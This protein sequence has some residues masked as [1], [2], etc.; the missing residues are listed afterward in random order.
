VVEQ[1]VE[2]IYEVEYVAIIYIYLYIT[3]TLI[4]ILSI[5]HASQKPDTGLVN[6]TILKAE[7]DVL[8]SRETVSRDQKLVAEK[9]RLQ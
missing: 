3:P 7:R 4:N 6:A 8:I 1:S 5:I 2:G 9:L